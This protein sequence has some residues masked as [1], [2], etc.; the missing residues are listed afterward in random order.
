MNEIG[1]CPECHQGKVT[2]KGNAFSCSNP[3]C[4]FTISRK[5]V[6][7]LLIKDTLNFMDY[8]IAQVDEMNEKQRKR[9]RLLFITITFLLVSALLTT[10]FFFKQ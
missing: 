10:L 6:A 8:A 1:D 4:D 9:D 3:K 5:S 2:D 7:D